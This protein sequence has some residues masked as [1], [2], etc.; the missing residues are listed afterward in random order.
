MDTKTIER[1]W[2]KVGFTN[3][4]W[5]WI[6]NIESRGYGIQKI[7]GRATR[8]HRI[9]YEL[10]VGPIPPD[11][12]L[13]HVC[14]NQDEE[15]RE[16]NYCLHRRCVNP[17][18]LEAVTH[19]ENSNRSHIAETAATRQ[20]IKTHCP[21]GHPFDEKNTYIR[22]DKVGRECRACRKGAIKRWLN[23]K[24]EVSLG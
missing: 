16:G 8:A 4:C 9:S 6:G 3:S 18:H 15:C 2:E 20:L 1:F 13:D 24:M 21:F 22:K 10:N 17:D 7:K 14:H 23:R 12:E 11:K 5:Y 19:K